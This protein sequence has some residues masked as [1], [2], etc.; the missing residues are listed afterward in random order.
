[1]VKRSQEE[2]FIIEVYSSSMNRIINLKSNLSRTLSQIYL[3]PDTN[4]VAY[5]KNRRLHEVRHI[6]KE[7]EKPVSKDDII[8]YLKERRDDKVSSGEYTGRRSGASDGLRK[9]SRTRNSTR[10]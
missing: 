7:F 8:D 1:V 2:F 5:E 6:A 10:L 3:R 9:S 4:I